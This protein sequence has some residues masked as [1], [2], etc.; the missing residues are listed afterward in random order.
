MFDR[1]LAIDV[2]LCLYTSVLSTLV[3]DSAFGR[4]DWAGICLLLK[5]TRLISNILDFKK[6]ISRILIFV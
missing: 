4:Q 3:H 6:I 1:Q 5:V 2:G